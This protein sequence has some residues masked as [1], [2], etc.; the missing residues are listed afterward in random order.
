MRGA[1]ASRAAS[2]GRSAVGKRIR[3]ASW[4]GALALVALASACVSHSGRVRCDG[5]LTPINDPALEPPG[6]GM[7]PGKGQPGS[8]R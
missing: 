4:L 3:L 2:S 6:A 7:V 5:R 8:R 1:V